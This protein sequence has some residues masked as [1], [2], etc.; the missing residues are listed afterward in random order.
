MGWGIARRVAVLQGESHLG[1]RRAF[2]AVLWLDDS[3][4]YLACK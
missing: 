3:F 4:L 1:T 2:G